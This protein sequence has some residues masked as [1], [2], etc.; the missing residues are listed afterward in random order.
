M[1]ASAVGQAG[2]A[3][4][5]EADDFDEVEGDDW[6][7]S[8]VPDWVALAPISALACR[9]YWLLRSYAN[10]ATAGGTVAFPGQALLATICGYAK[11]HAIGK[12]VA[13]LV[14]IGAV[15]WR[16]K[17]T[18]RG[19]RIVYRTYVE[20]R[21]DAGY[22][23]PAQTADLTPDV[24]AQMTSERALRGRGR[25]GAQVAQ[26]LQVAQDA[27]V[28]Q[29][30]QPPPVDQLQLQFADSCDT[31]AEPEPAPGQDARVH[32][33]EQPPAYPARAP[34]PQRRAE[35]PLTVSARVRPGAAH[36][37]LRSS[38]R[39]RRGHRRGRRDDS[40]NGPDP[41]ENAVARMEDLPSRGQTGL[42]PRGQRTSNQGNK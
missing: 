12:A 25:A 38:E 32:H 36:G 10:K 23:G 31:P 42:P 20:P 2:D 18:A 37:P 5:V 28:H 15:T 21:P 4:E 14:A 17:P 34:R 30:V 19:R 16:W 39:A 26:A 35:R 11:T 33:D 7:F 13:E 9:V 22:R 6:P 27:Q 40:Q 41:P 1:T 29:V 3:A 8:I 24:L